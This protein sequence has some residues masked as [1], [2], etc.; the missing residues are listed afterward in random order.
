MISLTR[1]FEIKGATLQ[2]AYLE[3]FSPNFSSSWFLYRFNLL[4]P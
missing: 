3:N 2:F 1:N 4:H